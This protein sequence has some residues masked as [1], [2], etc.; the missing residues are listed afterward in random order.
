MTIEFLKVTDLLRHELSLVHELGYE[1]ISSPYLTWFGL[2]VGGILCRGRGSAANSA[3]CYCL[4][5]TS[6]D[7][8]RANVL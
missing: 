1:H 7:P 2:L 4:G 6:V 5:I 3:I 8:A